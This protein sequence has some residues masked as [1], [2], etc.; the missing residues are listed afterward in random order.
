M[1][2]NPLRSFRSS[3]AIAWLAA[4][5]A[6]SLF[7]ILGS[8]AAQDVEVIDGLVG[9][10]PL[11]GDSRDH[12]GNGNHGTNRGVD[13]ASGEFNG[14]DAFIEIPAS[15]SLRLG[16]G[17]FSFAVWVFTEEQ[18]D[19]AVGDILELYDPARRRG[20]TLAINSSASGYLSQGGDRHVYFGIDNAKLGEWQ[21]CG[22]PS[23]TSAYV[24]NSMVVFKGHLYAAVSEGATEADWAHVYRYE[25]GADGK[26]WTDIG[27]VGNGRT[28]GVMPLIVHNGELYAVTTTYDWTRVRE[29]DFDAGRAYRYGGGTTWE[30]IGA[31]NPENR[32]LNTASSFQGKLYVGGGPNVWGVSVLDSDGHWKESKRFDKSGPQKVFP[33]TMS[34]Y[35]GRLYCGWPS[36]WAFDGR[37]WVHAGVPVE[38]EE[39][40]QTHSL[41]IY[42]GKLIAGTWPLAKVSEYQG[43]QAWR[44]FGRVGEDGSEVNSLVVYNGKLYGGSIPRAECCRYDGEPQ[45][46]S[47]RRFYSPEGWNPAPPAPFGS[48]TREEVANWSRI[49]SMTIHR[50]RLFA[51]IGNCTSSIKDS[52]ADI[53]G[54]VHSIEAGKCVSF[55]EE[56]APGWRHIAAVREG[57]KLK[58]YIDGELGAESAP[59]E[60]SDYDL[61]TD[62]PL[63]IGFGQIDYFHGKLRDVRAYKRALSVTEVMALSL[64]APKSAPR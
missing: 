64:T 4:W 15:D 38:P 21:D 41:A 2:T 50:G 48:P 9:H 29:G 49:T 16:T 24:N 54:S 60:A 33:H 43:G 17:D 58:L 55:D 7:L 30:D 31:P 8:S 35:N 53:R 61:S 3:L 1:M 45:W 47:L 63:R 14:E 34:R 6:C 59:F 39:I 32:T 23:A 26:Q 52:P 62:R 10:W 25:G 37:E 13:L 18:L 57:G 40:L 51:S 19:D 22:R 5:I 42:R 44:E 11:A 28:T 46:T 12:S 36:V 56:L 20:I 27:R